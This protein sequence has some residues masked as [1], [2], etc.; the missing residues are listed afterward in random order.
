MSSFCGLTVDGAPD[1]LRVVK[2]R[3]IWAVVAA[4]LLSGS[5]FGVSITFS[6]K[7]AALKPGQFAEV[8]TDRTGPDDLPLVKDESDPTIWKG[9]FDFES[10]RYLLY[11]FRLAGPGTTFTAVSEGD[12]GR[13]VYMTNDVIV[14]PLARFNGLEDSFQNTVMFRIDMRE[15]I[16]IGEFDPAIERIGLSGQLRDDDPSFRPTFKKSLSLPGVYESTMPILTALPGE[17]VTYNYTVSLGTLEGIAPRSFVLQGGAQVLPLDYYDNLKPP[18]VTGSSDG[19]LSI[20]SAPEQSVTIT[21][22]GAVGVH[23]QRGNALA[24]PWSTVSGTEGIGSVALKATDAA[25][26]FRLATDF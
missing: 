10:T 26:F 17:K 21:W 24:G 13:V 12:P 16:A 6:V 2:T 19:R 1:M 23:L 11:R 9:T 14:L 4:L 20:E 5:S 7:I 18:P 15:A 8:E 25:S 3:V 22:K